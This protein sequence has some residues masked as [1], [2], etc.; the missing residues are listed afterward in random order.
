[1][2]SLCSSLNS[3]PATVIS[4]KQRWKV[5]LY[6]YMQQK[7]QCKAYIKKGKFISKPGLHLKKVMLYVWWDIIGVIYY[8][9]VSENETI[10]AQTYYPQLQTLHKNLKKKCPS[11]VNHNCVFFLHD[12]ARPCITLVT[13]ED[14]VAL[15]MAVS[16]HPP[17]SPD[18]VYL[19]IIYLDYCTIF[20]WKKSLL[21]MNSSK[22]IISVSLHLNIKK[23]TPKNSEI[24][25]IMRWNTILI[26]Y[27]S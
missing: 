4:H 6:N 3:P 11:L 24:F 26:K 13:Q 25:R 17:Y 23:V 12:N 14:I 27:V 2:I 7:R 19:T 9:V 15:N 22:L 1:M 21:I 18:L 16:P 8:E 5:P 10:N 20:S